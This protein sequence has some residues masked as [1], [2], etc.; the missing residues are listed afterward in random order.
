MELEGAE[1][2]ELSD[3]PGYGVSSDGFVW[4]KW[5]PEPKRGMSIG[6]V[7]QKLDG[8][9]DRDG[10]KKVI[11]CAFGKRRYARVHS[12]ILETFVGPCPAGMVGAH[13]NGNNCDNR[14]SNLRWD[15]QKRNIADK[16]AHG[17]HQA[18]ERH[19]CHKL[20]EIQVREIRRR[21]ASGESGIS[22]AR[23][24][25]VWNGTISAIVHRR[26]WSHVA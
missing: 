14:I 10:Y 3:F 17:T 15:T 16:V 24:F 19:G 7:W 2:K 23:E 8:G 13:A 9:T 18:G 22:L 6:T 20:T 4:S 25:G 5:R 11:L 26:L 1:F 21:R 12:L